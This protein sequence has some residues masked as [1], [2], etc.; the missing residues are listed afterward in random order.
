LEAAEGC[1][2]VLGATGGRW[3]RCSL[4]GGGGGAGAR[5][6]FRAAGPANAAGAGAASS[7]PAHTAAAVA[8]AGALC[9]PPP[10]SVAP[11][12]VPSSHPND[13][14]LHERPKSRR[15]GGFGPP[16]GEDWF[17]E[18]GSNSMQ[19]SLT[20]TVRSTS[21]ARFTEG[22]AI[23]PTSVLSM[24]FNGERSPMRSRIR[25]SFR[26]SSAFGS[27]ARESD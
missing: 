16:V 8:G 3:A 23:V 13:P 15:P 18:P 6:G 19:S 21:F 14:R 10:S 27:I 22:R 26:M 1:W 25:R 12:R 24:S 11:F 5:V 4:L 20:L 9:V 17:S 2:G 7:S